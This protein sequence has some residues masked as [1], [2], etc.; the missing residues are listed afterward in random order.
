MSKTE[1]FSSRYPLPYTLLSRYLKPI[2]ETF[3]YRPHLDTLYF[4]TLRAFIFYPIYNLKITCLQH[5]FAVIF[6]ASRRERA[7]I[8]CGPSVNLT[9]PIASLSAFTDITQNRF[10]I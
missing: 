9:N 7:G 4:A 5:I 10:M 3:S 8:E 1:T 6:G 2:S